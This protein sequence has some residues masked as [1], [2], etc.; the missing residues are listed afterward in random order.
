M[1][2]I[3]PRYPLDLL[4][5]VFEASDEEELLEKYKKAGENKIPEDIQLTIE[6]L[7]APDRVVHYAVMYRYKHGMTLKNIAELTGRK[8]GGSAKD[9]I[10]KALNLMRSNTDILYHGYNK[11]I[12]D[13]KEKASNANIENAYLGKEI[14]KIKKICD[15]YI[16]KE[17][18]NEKLEEIEGIKD[19]TKEILKEKGAI[20]KDSIKQL[21]HGNKLKA[22]SNK[23]LQEVI[24]AVGYN[25]YLYEIGEEA[26]KLAE[27][28]KLDQKEKVNYCL[29]DYN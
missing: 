19:S 21:I 16:K 6:C 29:H 10:D 1:N 15:K 28:K 7:L 22:L 4:L 14:D 20:D 27:F 8:S 11:Y 18:K 9:S 17:S 2:N 13:L 3:T 5:D 12:E 25:Q 26:K 24:K 23:E